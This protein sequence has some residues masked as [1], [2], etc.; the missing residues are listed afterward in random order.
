MMMGVHFH[1]GGRVVIYRNVFIPCISSPL[2]MQ[3]AQALK[4]N[5]QG[6]HKHQQLRSIAEGWGK[7][8]CVCVCVCVCVCWGSVSVLDWKS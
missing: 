6:L 2:L 1:E 7:G 3:V 4:L 8:R 5:Y